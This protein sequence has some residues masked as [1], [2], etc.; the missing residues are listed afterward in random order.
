M[1]A[2]DCPDTETRNKLLMAFLRE[3][4]LMVGCG[5]KGIRFRPHLVVKADEIRLGIDTI[6]KVL[7]KGDYAKLKV[8]QDTCM[9]R[10]T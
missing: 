1:C 8:W 6:R 10:G 9:V 7:K 4:L 2:F 3:K 5:E